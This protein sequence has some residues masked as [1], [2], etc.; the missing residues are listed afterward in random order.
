M[1]LDRH[2]VEMSNVSTV[3]HVGEVGS[4]ELEHDACGTGY[5]SSSPLHLDPSVYRIRR[6][7]NKRLDPFLTDVDGG[8]ANLC[9]MDVTVTCNTAVGYCVVDPSGHSHRLGTGRDRDGL[10][11]ALR[12]RWAG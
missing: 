8:A 12:I 10:C 4:R 3:S 9:A 2:V 6:D 5:N 11:D 1:E 7:M